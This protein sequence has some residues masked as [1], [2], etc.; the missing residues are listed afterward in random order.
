M[1]RAVLS[2]AIFAL[3]A[4][5]AA[6][7]PPQAP[8]MAPL[9]DRICLPLLKGGTVTAAAAS[10]RPLAFSESAR[11]ATMVTMA[12]DET[13]SMTLGPAYCLIS[14]SPATPT[15]FRTAESE[16]RAWL[17]RLGRYWAGPVESDAVMGV[18]FRKYRAGGFTVTIEEQID[19]YGRRLN[20]TLGP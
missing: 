11:N 14:L 4:G 20:V 2:F 15:H 9:I 6:A 7:Q 1:K 18:R 8:E 19:E 3:A 10:A 5:A 12:R 13:F 16:L 17:P